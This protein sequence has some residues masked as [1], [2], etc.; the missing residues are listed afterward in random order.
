MVRSDIIRGHLDSIIL[1]LISE[2]DRYGY[3]ISQEISLRTNNRFQIKEATLY[4]IFQ[5]LEKRE[6]IEA[7]YGDISHGGKRKYYRI[8]PLGKAYLNELVKEW[9]EVKEIIDLFMEGLE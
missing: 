7:Y 9:M 2:K 1:R 3:E 4:A 8:T 6:I 5:R